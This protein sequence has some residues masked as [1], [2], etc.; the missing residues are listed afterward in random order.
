MNDTDETAVVE[1]PY[2]TLQPATLRAVVEEFVTR[3]TTDYGVR[4]RTLEERVADVM[5]Q[6]HR[7]E[8]RLV[9]DAKMGTVNIVPKTVAPSS[10]S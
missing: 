9:F 2:T 8:A 6:L 5:R 3:D 4:E 1:V 10:S 7:G